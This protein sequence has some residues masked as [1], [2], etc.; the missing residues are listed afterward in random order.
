MVFLSSNTSL[1][2]PCPP[3]CGLF[4]INGSPAGELSYY[5]KTAPATTGTERNISVDDTQNSDTNIVSS[6]VTVCKRQAV[7][8]YPFLKGPI[9]K[10]YFHP[11]PTRCGTY[12]FQTSGVEITYS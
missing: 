12:Y 7:F 4:L 5:K 1:Y 9:C 6:P 11:Y 10:T 3:P 2:F 8:L